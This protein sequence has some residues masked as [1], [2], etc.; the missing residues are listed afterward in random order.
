MSRSARLAVCTEVRALLVLMTSDQLFH[1][2]DAGPA[3]LRRP[4]G[5]TD[6]AG[7]PRTFGQGSIDVTI[8]D[9]ATVADD[10]LVRFQSSEGDG[11]GGASTRRRRCSRVVRGQVVHVSP[12]SLTR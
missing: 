10:H 5:S 4:R 6:S 9:D 11:S 2:E 7:R 8:R 12:I 1:R 3:L